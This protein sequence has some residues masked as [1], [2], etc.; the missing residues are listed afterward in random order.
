MSNPKR[1][2][3]ERLEEI[4]TWW[5]YDPVHKEMLGHITALEA[6]LATA[7]G[8]VFTIAK[9]RDRAERELAAARKAREMFCVSDEFDATD[10]AC[11]AWWRGHDHAWKKARAKL[12]EARALSARRLVALRGMAI[13]FYLDSAYCAQCSP[14]GKE[15][16]HWKTGAPEK[17]ILYGDMPC[18]AAPEPKE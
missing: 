6:D 11:P 5:P 9:D 10:A 13:R 8:A 18:P 4:R 17:H 3:A 16:A 1:L 14:S 2:S 15:D 12:A 7:E